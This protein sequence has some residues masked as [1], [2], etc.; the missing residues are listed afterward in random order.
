MNKK[1]KIRGEI[2]QDLFPKIVLKHVKT[3]ERESC[4]LPTETARESEQLESPQ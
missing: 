2:S 1:S 4:N 3:R